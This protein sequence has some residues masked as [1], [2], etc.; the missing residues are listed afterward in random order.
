MSDDSRTK[1][2]GGVVGRR[3]YEDSNSHNA[4]RAVKNTADY[5][6]TDMKAERGRTD[7][8]QEY[9]EGVWKKASQLG[10]KRSHI[11]HTWHP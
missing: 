2:L 8:L 5:L 3:P 7:G 9:D 1:E 10:N 4:A 11:S 6:R